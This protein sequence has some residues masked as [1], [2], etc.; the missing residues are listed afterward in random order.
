MPIW[1]DLTGW[2][3]VLHESSGVMTDEE[4]DAYVTHATALLERRERH[5]VIID[6]R[7]ITDVSPYARAAKKAWLEDNRELLERYCV[8]TAIVLDS[9]I[10]RFIFATI[11]LVQ[12]FPIPYRA[13]ASVDE[14][15]VWARSQLDA[16]EDQEEAVS[17]HASVPAV[18][19]R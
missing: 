11:L 8:G 15:R 14:A 13:F 9:A 5:A 17:S 6:A 12:P 16:R 4:I 3:I 19:Q 7:T 10:A 18:Q 1:I 2:P